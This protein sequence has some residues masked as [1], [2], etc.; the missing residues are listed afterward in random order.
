MGWVLLHIY[1]HKN[2][3]GN[4]AKFNCESFHILWYLNTYHLPPSLP[5][6][7]PGVYHRRV[8]GNSPLHWQEGSRV[9]HSSSLRRDSPD[10]SQRHGCMF[11]LSSSTHTHSL[12]T[13]LSLSLPVCVCVCCRWRYLSLCSHLAVCTSRLTTTMDSTSTPHTPTTTCRHDSGRSTSMPLTSFP[14]SAPRPP[15]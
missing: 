13:S 4:T 10:I 5:P 9:L 7:L 15:K 8:Q 11:Q 6:S 1:Q 3:G 12:S 14:S 2:S